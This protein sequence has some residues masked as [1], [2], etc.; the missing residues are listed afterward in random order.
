VVTSEPVD[1][2]LVAAAA[3]RAVWDKKFCEDTFRQRIADKRPTLADFNYDESE[4][5]MHLNVNERMD[6]A[7]AWEQAE[8][9][10]DVATEPIA[11]PTTEQVWSSYL[12]DQCQHCGL[13]DELQ[14]QACCGNQCEYVTPS[15]VIADEIAQE[16][17]PVLLLPNTAKDKA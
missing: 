9:E 1:V 8:Y 3:I 13:S 14:I 16:R 2:D 7:E 17:K 12:G 6:E 5:A 4:Y 11:T 10:L 15:S